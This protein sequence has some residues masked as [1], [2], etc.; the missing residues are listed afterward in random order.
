M[1]A[2]QK[3]TVMEL[4]NMEL[5]AMN[6]MAR[7]D[8]LIHTDSGT[9]VTVTQYF[10]DLYRF[11]KLHP[12]KTEFED[13]FK[14]QTPVHETEFFR[15]WIDD[16]LV[17]R[18]IGEFFFEKNH[19]SDA[20]VIFRQIVDTTKSYELFEKIGY[21]YQQLGDFEQ[22]L[23]YYNKAALLDKNRLWLLNRIAWVYRKT[24][25]YEKALAFYRDA[26][27]LEPDN[28]QVQAWLGQTNMEMEN[29]GEALKYYFKVEYLQ[30]E[31]H[32]VQRPISWCSFMLGKLE[33][34]Q[35]Y[36]EKT[37][38]SGHNKNDFLN[39]GHIYWCMGNKQLAIENYRKSLR[40][41]NLDFDWFARTLND[42]SRHLISHG[43]TSF[44]IPLMID[45]M[46]MSIN[47]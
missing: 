39:L 35:K 24:G 6:E 26:E 31:N 12:L 25:Q 38:E 22:A 9:K 10:H 42:D 18:N 13:I 19:Y 36:L 11:F 5:K 8:E 47:R 14:I 7:D 28:L 27:K 3:S 33:N 4:F 41:S 46:R 45:Y 16:K 37:L 29:Y 1:P 34:A 43:I 23:E 40:S 2:F 15:L 21:C 44:D 30:P 17:L 32:K 20:L